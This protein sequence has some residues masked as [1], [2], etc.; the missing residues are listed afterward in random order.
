MPFVLT[1]LL[2]LSSTICMQ[3]QVDPAAPAPPGARQ[4]QVSAGLMETMLER[5]VQPIYPATGQQAHA[6]EVVEL[7]IL[8]DRTGQV[9]D[10]EVISGPHLLVSAAVRAVRQWR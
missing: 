7:G 8:I 5:K 2:L 10:I 3:V 1:T 6:A 4:I 9:K